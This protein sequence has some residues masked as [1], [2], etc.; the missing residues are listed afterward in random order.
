MK[1]AER[2]AQWVYRVVCDECDGPPFYEGDSI[3]AAEQML[4]A[5]RKIEDHNI[6][7]QQARIEWRTVRRDL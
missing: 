6:V 4:P 2:A 7:I 3:T 1:V 5:L